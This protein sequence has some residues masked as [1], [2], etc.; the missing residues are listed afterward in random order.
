MNIE[1]FNAAMRFD[2]ISHPSVLSVLEKMGVI[3]LN[4]N[5]KTD[6]K[7]YI[8]A[9]TYFTVDGIVTIDRTKEFKTATFV[10]HEFLK[11]V[12]SL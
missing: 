10:P 3:V 1:L 7:G 8:V 12:T 5:C 4:S 6:S 2:R 9:D 11:S